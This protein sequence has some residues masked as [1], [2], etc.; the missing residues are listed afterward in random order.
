M[1]RARTE[2]GGM[3]TPPLARRLHRTGTLGSAW[4]ARCSPRSTQG[5]CLPP[6][7]G[8]G[9]PRFARYKETCATWD[10]TGNF[11]DEISQS[12]SLNASR[13]QPLIVDD[14]TRTG[15]DEVRVMGTRSWVEAHG[16]EAG[17]S[18]LLGRPRELLQS[19]S[20]VAFESESVDPCLAE[21]QR[22]YQPGRRWRVGCE[23]FTLEHQ[24]VQP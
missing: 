14:P 3:A 2:S 20:A 13:A 19:G 8:S 9:R 7:R 5:Y 16:L 10:R 17:H 22:Q 4:L 23:R 12:A 15:D 6:L 1:L 24:V 11:R 18:S 21:L